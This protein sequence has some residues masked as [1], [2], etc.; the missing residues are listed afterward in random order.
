MTTTKN[1]YADLMC[2]LGGPVQVLRDGEVLATLPSVDDAFVWILRHQGQSVAYA[3]RWG[4]YRVVA[5][6]PERKG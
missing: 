4:G 1:P 6:P 3:L 2:V 5:A